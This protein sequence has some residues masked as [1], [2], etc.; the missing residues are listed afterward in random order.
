MDDIQERLNRKEAE[1]M[2][3]L[4]IINRERSLYKA[5]IE[6]LKQEFSAI[7]KSKLD[8]EK[9]NNKLKIEI[10]ANKG[11]GFIS[12]YVKK[13]HVSMNLITFD[14]Y[15]GI[16]KLYEK[17]KFFEKMYTEKNVST[18]FTDAEEKFGYLEQDAKGNYYFIDFKSQKYLVTKHIPYKLELEY[19]VKAAVTESKEAYVL[20]IYK[21]TLDEESLSK[22]EPNSNNLTVREKKEKT[23]SLIGNFSVLLIGHMV[24]KSQAERLKLHGL[25]AKWLDPN[26]KSPNHILNEITKADVVLIFKNTMNHA[27]TNKITLNDPKIITLQQSGIRFVLENVIKFA[28]ELGLN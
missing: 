28:D 27:V 3:L 1:I 24:G 7:K 14:Q 5:H 11:M 9:E 26:E 2:E 19:P 15:R 23:Y 12:K 8:L 18:N 13:L 25:K 21:D 17:Y 20:Y 4:E 6:K 10:N 22:K 16:P